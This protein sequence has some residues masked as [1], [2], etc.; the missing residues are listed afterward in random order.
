MIKL[1][2]FVL[3]DGLDVVSHWYALFDAQ[4]K[5]RAR[6][7][8]IMLHLRQQN[9]EGWR[10]EYYDTLRDGVGE[11]RFKI[12]D[13][14]YRPLGSFVPGKEEF[15]FT[16]FA[17]KNGDFNPPNAIDI[18]VARRKLIEKYPNRSRYVVGRWNQS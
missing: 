4:P 17:T 10:R 12:F 13:V 18:A 11:V 5:V 14:N 9:R 16:Y 8:N 7:D 2:A 6:L 15:T 3:D 1:R